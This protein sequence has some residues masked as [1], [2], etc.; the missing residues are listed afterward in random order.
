MNVKLTMVGASSCI[1]SILKDR[2][3][4]VAK[5]ASSYEVMAMA[6]QRFCKDPVGR[7]ALET[8]PRLT[9]LMSISNGSSSA[10][11]TRLLNWYSHK[12]LV[13]LVAFQVVL[14]IG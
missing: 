6:V 5:K 7:Q 13:L 2:L 10:K 8:G 1:V 14:Q 4:A 12:D 3:N 9:P 11:A